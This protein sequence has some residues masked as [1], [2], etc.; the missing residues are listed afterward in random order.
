MGEVSGCNSIPNSTSLYGGSPGS[1]SGKHPHTRTLLEVDLSLVSPCP[2]G[3]GS[4]AN[5]LTVPDTW[6]HILSRAK[7][8]ACPPEIPQE[9]CPACRR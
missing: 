3:Y 1:S 2:L 4:R 7:Y 6:T 9:Y 5:P 8:H